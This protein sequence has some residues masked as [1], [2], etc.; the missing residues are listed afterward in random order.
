MNIFQAA[1]HNDL[2]GLNELLTQQPEQIH[3]RE[4][5]GQWTALHQATAGG[6]RK[7]VRLLLSL[8][9]DPNAQGAAGES[10]LH[11]VLERDVAEELIENGADPLLQDHE[12]VTPLDL[13]LE[14]RSEDLYLILA[15]GASDLGSPN[16]QFLQAARKLELQVTARH[17]EHF[18]TF[19]IHRLG[20]NEDVEYCQ[21]HGA[22]GWQCLA[23][24]DLSDLYFAEPVSA[25][26]LDAA[27][28]DCLEVVAE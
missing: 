11:L 17:D 24:E 2:A 9:A 26:P 27:P 5:P 14:D 10:A 18:H 20:W 13:A 8:G 6:N 4:T 1:R 15:A 21:V 28:E 7:A 23:V 22:S 3:A 25:T 19:R 16:F 12:G